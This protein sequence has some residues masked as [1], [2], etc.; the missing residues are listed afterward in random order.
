MEPSESEC[1]VDMTPLV[2]CN[3]EVVNGFGK[4]VQ[5]A[6]V[7]AGPNIYWWNGGSQIYGWPL[8]SAT[9]M[10]LTGKYEMKDGEGIHAQPFKSESDENGRLTIELPV[11]KARLWASS[12]RYQL[13][14]KMGSREHTLKVA[15]GEPIEVKLTLQ[16]KGLDVL[17]DWEDLCGFVFG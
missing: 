9:Q 1:V 2:S 12:K 16:P 5:G 17:G 13:P 11:G 15:A 6:M 3:I 7:A 14:I 4:P 10:L 8:V